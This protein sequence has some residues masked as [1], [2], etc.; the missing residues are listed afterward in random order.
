M[1]DDLR[2]TTLLQ[3]LKFL[4][5]ILINTLLVQSIKPKIELVQLNQ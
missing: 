3:E 5:L 4:L 1:L 2:A